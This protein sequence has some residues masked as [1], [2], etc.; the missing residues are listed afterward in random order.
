MVLHV[1]AEQ[2]DTHLPLQR[3]TCHRAQ[4]ACGGDLKDRKTEQSLQTRGSV[5][6]RTGRSRTPKAWRNT[7]AD[8]ATAGGHADSQRPPTIPVF[9]QTVPE[10]EAGSRSLMEAEE[11]DRMNISRTTCPEKKTRIWRTRGN[12]SRNRDTGIGNCNRNRKARNI[13]AKLRNQGVAKA[14]T[15]DTA[16]AEP[17]QRPGELRLLQ[18]PRP[19]AVEP[20]LQPSRNVATGHSD[21]EH[22]NSDWSTC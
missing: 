9:Y 19:V 17:K 15:T 5:R 2:L 7:I 1:Q 13:K 22:M 8:K 14:N 10:Y 16:Q 6:S 21:T 12:G 11:A 4:Q 3:F 20:D 18:S